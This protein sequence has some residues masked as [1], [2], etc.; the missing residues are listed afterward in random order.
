MTPFTVA[1]VQLAISEGGASAC[2]KEFCHDIVIQITST[3]SRVRHRLDSGSK[4]LLCQSSR[5]DLAASGI[6]SGVTLRVESPE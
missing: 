4:T 1:D 6:E 2:C 3:C 5:V